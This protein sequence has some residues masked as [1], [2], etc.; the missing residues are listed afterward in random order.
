MIV[1]VA[2]PAL[3]VLWPLGDADDI[4]AGCGSGIVGPVGIPPTLLGPPSPARRRSPILP[5][6]LLY[7]PS[8]LNMAAAV[9]RQEPATLES[10]AIEGRSRGQRGVWNMEDGKG[11]TFS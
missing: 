8:F 10:D 1:T 3:M 9:H 5:S 2:M 7:F 4:R 6:R 11:V